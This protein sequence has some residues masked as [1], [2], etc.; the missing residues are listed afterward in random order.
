MRSHAGPNV[1]PELDGVNVRFRL[2]FQ[3]SNSGLGKLKNL[4]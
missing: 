1:G 4:Q 3:S 2:P